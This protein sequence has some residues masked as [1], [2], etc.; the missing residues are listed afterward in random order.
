M[1]LLHCFIFFILTGCSLAEEAKPVVSTNAPTARMAAYTVNQ[2]VADL[3]SQLSRIQGSY[4]GN[5]RIAVTSFYMA[6]G[7]GT[8]LAS[9]QGNGLSQQIQESLMTQFTQLG[10]HTIE[11]R[12][13][14]TLNLQPTADSILSRDVSKLRQR[15][16]I[17]FVITGT[18]TRQQHAYIVNARL[19]NTKDQ[20]I[21]S[22]ASTEIPINVMWG[23]EKVQQRD[24]QL[25]RS[26]Y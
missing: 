5:A 21:V 20:R 15:Q 11:Y 22:A 17:D 1:R 7:L 2:Y 8:R 6:D 14:N 19:V 9:N 26:E 25:Y 16:N 4:K 12:L 18:L 3:S 10:F 23:N 24:G 13:E